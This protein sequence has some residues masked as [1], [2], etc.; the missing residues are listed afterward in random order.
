MNFRG[1]ATMNPATPKLPTAPHKTGQGLNVLSFYGSERCNAMLGKIFARIKCSG[2]AKVSRR[3]QLCR[4]PEPLVLRYVSLL[5]AKIPALVA[6]AALEG[7]AGTVHWLGGLQIAD[8]GVPTPRRAVIVMAASTLGL[9]MIL[10]RRR[11]MLAGLG[12]AGLACSAFW[13]CAGPVHPEVQAGVLEVTTIDV[14]QGDSILLVSP[15]GQ[16]LLVDAGGLP[17]WAHSELDIG[18]DVVSPYLWWRGFRKLDAVTVTHA[19]SDHMGGMTAVLANFRPR[20]LWLGSD[21]A[22]TEMKAVVKRARELGVHVVQHRA[23]EGFEFGGDAVRILAPDANDESVK[24]ND[25]SLVMQL[26]WGSTSALLEGDAERPTEQ[27]LLEDHPEADLL[28]VAHHGSATSTRADLA[29]VHPK[30]A[31][32]SVGARNVRAPAARGLEQAAGIEH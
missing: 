27:R 4:K 17:H 24:K 12:L 29:A 31:V 14:G 5:L 7:I 26:T 11:A 30:F 3:D 20:E 16:T 2:I 18:E 15:S 22:S 1:D 23:G 8:A 32:I 25:E 13:I 10:I 19:H 9:A 21:E 6:G 28:K